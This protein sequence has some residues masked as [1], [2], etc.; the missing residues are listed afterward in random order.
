MSDSNILRQIWPLARRRALIPTSALALLAASPALAQEGPATPAEADEAQGGLADIVVTATRRATNLQ[1][2]PLAVTAVTADALVQQGLTNAADLSRIIPNASFKRVQ[3]AFGNGM[4]AFIRGIGQSDTSLANEPGVAFYVDDVYYP[5]VFGSMFDLLDLDHVEV[6]RGPQGTLFGR[7]ALAGAVNLVSRK[8]SLT[9]ATAF[10]EVTVGSY[11]RRDF[12]FGFNLPISETMAFSITAMSKERDGYQRQLDF[13][14]EMTKI[15][16]PE[17]AGRIPTFDPN[18]LNGSN[19]TPT[20]DCT[21]GRLGSEDMRAMRGQFLWEPTPDLSLTL[22]ADYMKDRSTATPDTLIAI[23]PTLA[24]NNA[25]SRN[26]FAWFTQ[27]GG[28]TVAFDNRFITGNP[29]STYATFADPIAAGT[30]VPGSPFYNGS[31]FRGGARNPLVNPLTNWGVSGKLFYGVAKDIDLTLIVGYRKVETLFSFDVDGSPV[32]LENNRNDVVQDDYS[33]EFRVSGKLDWVDW[34]AGLFYYEADGNQRFTG[35]SVYNNTM[36][37]QNNKYYPKSKAA[38]VNLNL[39][40]IENLGITLGGRYSDDE[41]FVDFYS[42]LDGTT[43]ASTVFTAAPTGST[44]FT[45]NLADKR[46]DWKLGF[47]Y[48]LGDRT[49]VYGSAATGFRLPGFNAR[50]LQPSQVVQYPGE[51]IITY[52]LGLKTDLFD[53]RLRLN[54]AAFYT[55][56]K[57]RISSTT[58]QEYRLDG[59][60][61]RIPLAAPAGQVQVDS[62]AGQGTTVC[63][64][65]PVGVQGYECIGRTF[66]INTPGKVKGFEVEMQANPVDALS[67]NASIGYA[68]FT[69]P[70]L[71]ARPANN[72]KRLANLPEWNVNAGVQ[73]EIDAPAI[74]GSVTPRLDWFYTGSMIY[75]P[76]RLEWNQPGY[77]IVNAR[78]TYQNSDH[79]F[80]I[81]AGVTNLFNQFY[82]INFFIY[83]DLGYPQINGQPSAPRQWSLTVR[84]EF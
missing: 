52:E 78:L 22:S 14:C 38:F 64:P 31:P 57:S 82:W 62:T 37:F 66:F 36:R 61:N 28:P 80:S 17:F 15:G 81:A 35:T 67:F 42:V 8:P 65:A 33:G 53:R 56:Y 11:R 73:Y 54:A 49:M 43:A 16:H 27:P 75:S 45:I 24:A 69:A 74:G 59:N 1:D 51:E 12:R 19:V 48:Q 44:I 9:E 18:I 29:Y 58:G 34:V 3:G 32:V 50:A 41:K 76:T 70:D 5:L 2:T 39:H 26:A 6:L 60:G 30:V 83:Q 46:F 55:D 13:R 4:S 40:P 84:K 72:N 71:D 63:Q 68:K 47:D 23:N 20:Q 7:N 21:I 79:D 77:S 10:G 25:S